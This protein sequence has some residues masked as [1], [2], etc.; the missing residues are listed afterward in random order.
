MS[1]QAFWVLLIRSK[2]K[3][4]YQIGY[5]NL[6]LIQLDRANHCGL[7]YLLY[8]IIAM[9]DII[10]DDLLSAGLLQPAWPSFV[11]GIKCTFTITCAW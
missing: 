10:F 11:R 7:C 4:L 6:G 3:K 9:I 5:N 1:C 8:G 2:T